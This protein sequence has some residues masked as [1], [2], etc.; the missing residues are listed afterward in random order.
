MAN[1]PHDTDSVEVIENRLCK[2]EDRAIEFTQ[3]GQSGWKWAVLG[4]LEQ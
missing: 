4:T 2:T 3:S 1:L